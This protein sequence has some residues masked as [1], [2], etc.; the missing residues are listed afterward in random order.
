MARVFAEQAEAAVTQG[1]WQD[2]SAELRADL[3]PLRELINLDR[4]AVALR[5]FQ[6]GQPFS[7]CV[8]DGFFKP[9]W[10]AKLAGEFPAYDSP[11]WFVY[12]NP[13]EH[14]KALNDWNR[15]PAAT[16]R[17]LTRLN[18]RAF[19]D[20]LLV[21][22]VGVDLEPDSGL[23]GGGWHIHGQGGNL[24][25]HV[26]Y[27]IHPKLGLVRKL[28]LIIYL[29]ENLEPERHGGHFGLW[30]H[31][32]RTERPARLVKEVAPVFNRAVL[33]DTTQNSWHGMSR[34]LTVPAGVYRQSL[35]IYYLT[36]PSPDDTVSRQR[37]LYAPREGQKGDPAIEKLIRLRAD[38]AHYREAYVSH[39]S[40]SSRL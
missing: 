29:S 19:I 17:T 3:S 24:N 34:P 4:L 28:N 25:P 14:K 31:D 20:S 7:H 38:Q 30:T 5:T 15:Y 1:S 2:A 27:H 18:S 35:A 26:D 39:P 13:L 6:V 11:N 10:A 9:E 37:A 40:N 8:I 22:V 32:A 33:F 21:P 36:S 16:Y 23:H 12:D